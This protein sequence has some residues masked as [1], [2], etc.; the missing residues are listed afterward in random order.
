LKIDYIDVWCRRDEGVRF[1]ME[2]I[3]SFIALKTDKFETLKT[4]KQKVYM[5]AFA[6]QSKEK[7]CWEMI[8]I[9]WLIEHGP[10]ISCRWFPNFKFTIV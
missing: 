4:I 3:D 2:G 10:L 9:F 5:N 7:A 8:E 6:F 1:K